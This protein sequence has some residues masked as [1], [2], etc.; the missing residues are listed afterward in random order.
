M[1][2][3][4]QE[5]PFPPLRILY[6]ILHRSMT[7]LETLSIPSMAVLKLFKLERRALL[8]PMVLSSELDSKQQREG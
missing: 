6:L 3:C 4:S 2:V 5:N 1:K 7:E 8:R